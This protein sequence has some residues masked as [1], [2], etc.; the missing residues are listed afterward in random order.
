MRDDYLA[1]V[2]LERITPNTIT[3]V[4]KLREQLDEIAK[5]GLGFVNEEFTPGIV[6]LARPVLSRSGIPLASV[7]VAI[8]AVRFSDELKELCASEL[9]HAVEVIRQRSGLSQ[10]ARNHRSQL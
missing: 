4:P 6:G 2:K 10:R 3:S 9:A 1:R 7:N 8:P 5:T